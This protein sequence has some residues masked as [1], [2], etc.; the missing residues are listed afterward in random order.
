MAFDGLFQLVHRRVWEL[1]LFFRIS[2]LIHLL[3]YLFRVH[4]TAFLTLTLRTIC[5][6]SFDL[7]LTFL[8][9]LLLFCEQSFLALPFDLLHLQHIKCL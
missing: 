3:S 2:K 8:L 4:T 1:I 5:L 9:F 7:L 6:I